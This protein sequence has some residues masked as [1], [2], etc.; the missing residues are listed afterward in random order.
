M[1]MEIKRIDQRLAALEIDAM[2]IRL[3]RMLDLSGRDAAMIDSE[4][5]RMEARLKMLLSAGHDEGSDAPHKLSP[6]TPPKKEPI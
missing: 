2:G 3:G 1:E 4:I 5:G 6:Q